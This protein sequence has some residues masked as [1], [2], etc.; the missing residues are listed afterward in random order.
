MVGIKLQFKDCMKVT[1][2][3]ILEK[4]TLPQYEILIFHIK[5][6]FDGSG[7]KMS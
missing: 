3:R 1:A 5:F 4:E 6:G 2:E 7:I